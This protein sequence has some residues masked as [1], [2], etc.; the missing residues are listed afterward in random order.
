MDKEQAIALVRVFARETVKEF[1][2]MKIVLYG[3]YSRN[4]AH[5][6]SD[7]DAAVIFDGF[8]G[9]RYESSLRLW[10]IAGEINSSIAPK[11]LDIQKDA[12]GFAEEVL[13]VGEVIWS[14]DSG[15][16]EDNA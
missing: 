1:S 11:L 10:N 14:A 13:R 8:S 12:R 5:E 15:I 6:W 2:P 3:S 7:I 4:E 16:S 9:S